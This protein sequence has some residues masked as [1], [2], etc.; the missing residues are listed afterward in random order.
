L[1]LRLPDPAKRV[2]ERDGEGPRDVLQ[3]DSC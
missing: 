3:A 2:L 1:R